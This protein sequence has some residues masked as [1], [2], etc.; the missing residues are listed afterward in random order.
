M[1]NFD[2]ST[3]CMVMYHYVRPVKNSKHPK[4]KALELT[5]FRNQIK[6]FKKNYDIINF[7]DLTEILNK[8]KIFGKKKLILTFDDGYKDHYKYVLPELKKNKITGF[9]Y[10]PS[11]VVENKIVLDVNKIHF[12]LEKEEERKKILDDINFLLKKYKQKNIFDMNI[13]INL[14]KSRYDDLETSLVKKLLQF[15][16]PEKV[17]HKILNDLVEK[18]LNLSVR[19]FSKK[20]YINSKELVEMYKEGMHIGSHGE[21]HVRWGILSKKKQLQE[22]NNSIKFFKKLDFD[23]KKLS[24]CY[25]YGSYNKDTLKI[26]KQAGFNFGLTTDVGIISNKNLKNKFVFP[27]LNANDFLNL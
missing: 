23:I 12:I 15:L 24:V 22:I 5:E 19:D 1:I 18:Y 14:L 13:N 2:K 27:R 20:L 7:D 6:W 16:L 9:F 8:K 26:I 3:I 11:K 10:P 25:P 21:F 17:R 4:L